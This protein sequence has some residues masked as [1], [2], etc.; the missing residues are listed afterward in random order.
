MATP[1][2]GC[3]LA[4]DLLQRDAELAESRRTSEEL[5]AKMQDMKTKTKEHVKMMQEKMQL[6]IKQKDDRLAELE[7]QIALAATTGAATSDEHGVDSGAAADADARVAKM[8]EELAS[9][10]EAKIAEVVRKAKEHV[11]QVQT[12]LE[13]A[14][15]ENQELSTKHTDLDESHRQQQDKLTKYKQL[16]AQANTRIEESDENVKQL[17]EELNRVLADR[18]S[19]QGQLGNMDKRFNVPPTRE[20][21]DRGGGIETAVEA[22]NDDVWCLIRSVDP[23]GDSTSSSDQCRWWLL[24]QLD[25]DDK[26]VP[27]QRRWKGEVSAL[28][29]QMQRFKRRSEDLQE[30][31]DA[32]KAKAGQALQTN[33]SHSEEIASRERKLDHL[34]EQ[35]QSLTLSLQHAQGEKTKAVEDLTETRRKLLEASARRGELEKVLDTRVR[36]GE[37]RLESAVLSCKNSLK[38]EMDTLEQQWCEKERAYQQKLDLQRTQKESLDDEIEGLRARVT[39]L[40][41]A[42][43]AAAAATEAAERNAAARLAAASAKVPSPPPEPVASPLS[44]AERAELEACRRELEELRKVAAAE[45]TASPEA[46]AGDESALP[47]QAIN[48]QA[49]VAWQDL[50][51]LRQQV[52]QLEQEAREER[53]RAEVEKSACDTVR[54]EL[55]DLSQQQKLQTTVGQTQQMEYI[56]N[57]FKKFVESLPVGGTE[58]EQLIPVLM[59][60]F[61]FAAEDARTIQG[62]RKGASGFWNRLGR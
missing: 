19:M 45:G 46:S 30:E 10:S 5:E 6:V 17:R 42:G 31:F 32:Y 61:S 1:V 62:K 37:E 49:S 60:F 11:K 12:R 28:R 16:M 54:A 3:N 59:T 26:P 7:A 57:V 56:R 48:L 52:R 34:G 55:R 23:G 43:Q 53:E 40:A 9:E 20:E 47:P 8:Q 35:V 22:D 27:L 24:S 4:D 41:A 58:Q 50:V 44:T 39:Q 33:A 13:A 38:A 25:V 29:A 15:A 36:E 2:E 21:I 18:T 51:S 14:L